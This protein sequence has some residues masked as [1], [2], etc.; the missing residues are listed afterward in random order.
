MKRLIC[1]LLALMMLTGCTFAERNSRETVFAM[2]TV[3]DL[4]VWG[5][6]CQEAI[7]LMKEEI[8]DLENTWSATRQNSL[9]SRLNAGGAL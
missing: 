5:A 9:V 7:A 4:Q 8:T 1:I 2:D 6:D 3:M